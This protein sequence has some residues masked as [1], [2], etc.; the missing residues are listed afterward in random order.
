MKITKSRLK[1]LIKEE[2]RNIMPES[3]AG[4]EEAGSGDIKKVLDLLEDILSEVEIDAG[5][6]DEPKRSYRS[7]REDVD[8]IKAQIAGNYVPELNAAVELLRSIV[9]KPVARGL[10]DQELGQDE[11]AS[12][13]CFQL[14]EIMRQ[15][16]EAGAGPEEM[17]ELKQLMRKK[18]CWGI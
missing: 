5:A 10:G 11:I 3:K 1:Q 13:T 16:K 18:G 6:Y 8:R 17:M 15:K 9:E 4:Q 14:E 7:G 12:Y 2:V